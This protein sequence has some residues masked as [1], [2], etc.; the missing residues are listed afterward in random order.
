MGYF[1]LKRV[2]LILLRPPCNPP[3]L[4]V[5]VGGWVGGWGGISLP[6]SI[7]AG[8]P[9]KNRKKK[10]VEVVQLLPSRGHSVPFRP[11][12]PPLQV[13][14]SFACSVSSLSQSPGF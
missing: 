11:T 8:T 6:L 12:V 2:C 13:V 5:C 7:A 14:P 1:L 10:K 3:L 9:P 4:V